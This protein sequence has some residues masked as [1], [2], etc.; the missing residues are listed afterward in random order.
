MP[1]ALRPWGAPTAAQAEAASVYAQLSTADYR[2]Y[3]TAQAEHI[4]QRRPVLFAQPLLTEVQTLQKAPYL[5]RWARRL[6]ELMFSPEDAIV[7]PRT[8]LLGHLDHQ[9]FKLLINARATPRC[10]PL[11]AIKL[12]CHPL[13]MPG[14]DGVRLND[15]GDFF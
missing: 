9:F 3:T 4:L 5:R 8:I 2:L 7:T 1:G 6:R 10:P 11:G 13:E 15:V 14:Q 12:L